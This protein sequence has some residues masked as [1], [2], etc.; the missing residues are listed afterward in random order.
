MIDIGTGDGRFV[1]NAARAN[2]NKFF[3][4]IDANVKPL[5]KP[6]IKAT[7]KPGKGGLPNALFVQASAESLPDELAGIATEIRI[8]FPWGSLLKLVIEAGPQFLSSL[9]RIAAP[10]CSLTFLL[11]FDPTRDL[12]ELARLKIDPAEMAGL[13]GSVASKYL[14]AGFSPI[15]SD[16]LNVSQLRNLDSSWARRLSTSPDRYIVQIVFQRT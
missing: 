13:P 2:P 3:I 9:E 4:G 12:G 10:C 16:R 7:R 1:S 11:S 14:R 6:S 5:Q 8:Q 15:R